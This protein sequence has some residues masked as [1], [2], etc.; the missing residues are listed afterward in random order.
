MV[1]INQDVI[2]QKLNTISQQLEEA[3]RDLVEIRKQVG[4]VIRETVGEILEESRERLV[5]TVGEK[6][7]EPMFRRVEKK[8]NEFLRNLSIGITVL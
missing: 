6:L 2:K 7:E 1:E 5:E 4:S 3:D 8:V